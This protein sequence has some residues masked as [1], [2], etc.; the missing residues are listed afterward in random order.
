MAELLERR[1]VGMITLERR[2]C[3]G[4][5]MLFIEHGRLAAI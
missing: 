4:Q 1:R 2:T 3:A 5:G